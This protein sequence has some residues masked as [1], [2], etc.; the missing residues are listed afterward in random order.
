MNLLLIVAL[1]WQNTAIIVVDVSGFENTNGTFSVAIFKESN[2]FPRDHTR[3]WKRKK[4]KASHGKIQ[5][6]FNGIA[7]G[8][9]A[10]SVFHDENNSGKAEVNFIGMPKE[11]VGVSNNIIHQVPPPP[12]FKRALFKVTG[13]TTIDIQLRYF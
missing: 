6:E 11:G 9:Y 8:E 4:V 7:H 5:V 12:S 1:L 3:A 10:I 13:D 2:G